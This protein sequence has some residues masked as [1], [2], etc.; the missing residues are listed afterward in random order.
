M[1]MDDTRYTGA[2]W[3][4]SMKISNMQCIVTETDSDYHSAVFNGTILKFDWFFS[5]QY[6]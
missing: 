2:T 6:R 1:H 5:K 4:M 3:R